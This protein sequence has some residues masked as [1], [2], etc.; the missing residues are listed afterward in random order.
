MDMIFSPV[1]GR[2]GGNN[3]QPPAAGLLFLA[4]HP[5]AAKLIRSILL[6]LSEV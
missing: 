1:S 5:G 2:N 4:F 3:H 6:I